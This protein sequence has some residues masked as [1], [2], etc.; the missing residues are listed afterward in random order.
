VVVS[1]D[2]DL[3]GLPGW[4]VME[5][6]LRS[7]GGHKGF[8]AI[9]A[10]GYELVGNSRQMYDTFPLVLLDGTW[11]YK[12]L[13]EARQKA[14]FRQVAEAKQP[15]AVRSCFGGLALYR[16]EVWADPRCSYDRNRKG[17]GSYGLNKMF[18]ANEGFGANE[19]CEHLRLQNCLR[20]LREG[21]STAPLRIGIHPRLSASRG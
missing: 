21:S 2:L 14:F 6:A 20:A 8:D 1:V 15:V 11:M 12:H 3:H 10:N 4:G 18:G 7:L 16:V 17:G 13:G 9:C 19:A 5:S